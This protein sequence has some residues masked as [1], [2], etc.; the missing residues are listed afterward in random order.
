MTKKKQ[1][2]IIRNDQL[3]IEED[4]THEEVI[5]RQ[6]FGFIRS[7]LMSPV[8]ILIWTAVILYKLYFVYSKIF[9]FGKRR[10]EEKVKEE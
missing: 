10:H 1:K 8:G 7:F 2:I 6:K 9:L 3:L 4:H 5:K